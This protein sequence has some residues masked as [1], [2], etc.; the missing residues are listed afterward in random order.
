MKLLKLALI[1]FAL[2]VGAQGLSA[3][4]DVKDP[5]VKERMMLMSQIAENTKTLGKMAKGVMEFNEADAK[6]A[7]AKIAELS[8]AAPKA[9]EVQGDDPKSEALPIIWDEF[10]AF[11]DLSMT[12][13]AD[14]DALAG[15]VA[16]L[17]DL[18]ANMG[19]IAGG[20]KACHSKYRE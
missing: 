11:S 4:E 10:D 16:S 6:A 7:L 8:K 13:A 17:D 9:F 15:Q 2:A 18:R 3:H 12:L 20:C 5:N 19:K 14:A 1:P